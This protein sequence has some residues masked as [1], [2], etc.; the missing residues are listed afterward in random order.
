MFFIEGVGG[1]A[2][3]I[4]ID[5]TGS[6]G[7]IS[8]SPSPDGVAAPRGDELVLS[9]GSR[10]RT[11]LV[12]FTG[13]FA[14]GDPCIDVT[15]ASETNAPLCHDEDPNPLTGQDPSADSWVTED[16]ALF[17]TS[18]DP[19]I[20]E[21]RYRSDDGTEVPSDYQ[22]AMGP[23]GWTDPDRRVCVLPLPPQGSGTIQFLDADGTVLFEHGMGWG[24]SEAAPPVPAVD[25]VHGGTYWAV[26]PWVG[27]AD[28]PEA[29]DVSAQLLAE[30]GIEAFPGDLSC[31]EGAAAALGTN[32]P[33]G[34]GVYFETRD[35]AD[36]FALE[37]DAADDGQHA[38]IARVTT[39]CLD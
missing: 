6:I 10:G 8:P 25:P 2:G 17:V 35:D 36:A 23:T 26:Y 9:G 33:Q 15:I 5:G 1:T 39:Y 16:L 12:R 38:V 32:A 29:D 24:S 37:V 3:E 20:V 18:V 4:V 21:L 28:S 19:A 30:F 11:W 14:D 34:I 7:T 31:D 22:C 27:A 13:S